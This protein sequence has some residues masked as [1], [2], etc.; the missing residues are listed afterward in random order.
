MTRGLSQGERSLAE[1]GPLATVGGPLDKT[2]KKL[3]NDDESL[4][5]VDVYAS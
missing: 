1:R 5:V 2:Q 4:D 3:K